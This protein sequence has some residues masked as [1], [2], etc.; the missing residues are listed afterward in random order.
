MSRTWPLVVLLSLASACDEPH[1]WFN[2]TPRL[3]GFVDTSDSSGGC[4]GFPDFDQ[5]GYGEEGS[6]QGNVDCAF[7]AADAGD[8]NDADATVFPDAQER[9]DGIDSNCNG[10][11]DDVDEAAIDQ[12]TTYYDGDGDGYGDR[13]GGESVKCPTD[14]WV[15][16]DG[17]CN[18]GDF[19]VRPGAAEVCDGLDNDCDG[20][21]DALDPDMPSD[22][23]NSVY[24]ADLDGDS[25]GNPDVVRC[26]SGPGTVTNGNDCNDSDAS[27]H[28]NAAEACDDVDRDCSGATDDITQSVV[29]Y[30][31][32]DGDGWGS[33]TAGG[34][35]N[36]CTGGS[37]V[38]RSGD[39]DDE[40]IARY[41]GAI[42]IPYDGVMNDCNYANSADCDADRDGFF[43][44]QCSTVTPFDCN[45]DDALVHPGALQLSF[46]GVDSDCDGDTA[47]G[48][49]H[50]P[51]FTLSSVGSEVAA[52]DL[53]GDGLVELIS[54][55]GAA[56]SGANERLLVWPNELSATASSSQFGSVS[57]AGRRTFTDAMDLDRDGADD[58]LL[59][60]R[61]NEG[62]V[63]QIGGGT[64]VSVY[65]SQAGGPDHFWAVGDV[66][67]DGWGDVFVTL[68]S[69]GNPVLRHFAVEDDQ[70]VEDLNLS[71]PTNE[72][73]LGFS[74]A[75]IPGVNISMVGD[76]DGDGVEE[77][78]IG[79]PE[80]PG[81]GGDAFGARHILQGPD[82]SWD[83]G[84]GYGGGG[85]NVRLGIVAALGQGDFNGDGYNEDLSGGV[86]PTVGD[87]HDTELITFHGHGNLF[88]PDGT[89]IYDSFSLPTLGT[90]LV[91]STRWAGDVD[92]DGTDD[93][94]V[95]YAADNGFDGG[96]SFYPDA[97]AHLVFGRSTVFNG[98]LTDT[99]YAAVT[100]TPET[101]DG[102][103][104]GMALLDLDGHEP[105]DLVL[106]Q[107]DGG[108]ALFFTG[109][110]P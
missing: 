13:L 87:L 99:N 8:C 10:L 33:N 75:Y 1:G 27:I 94:W 96:Q 80:L 102:L 76:M 41:P 35:V 16:N 51:M 45:D 6:A 64:E 43:S 63:T 58:V 100:P 72:F 84:S 31:D 67:N 110:A 44:S 81:D 55:A 26:G 71:S 56:S 92:G 65:T 2:G 60:T 78:S 4:F 42:D 66:D 90:N 19:S 57:V 17:D 86:Y 83:S 95:S 38:G 97:G 37:L 91:V 85:Q 74:G 69:G 93:F 62:L 23:P 39:C 24:F 73:L 9:C 47:A 22:D 18:D 28:P 109:R 54:L 89:F 12:V 32:S 61:G 34:T 79:M 98:Y 101:H 50:K 11:S 40:D 107:D 7:V 20:L 5:D 3:A 21:A 103:A 77:V 36:S 49:D 68:L 105:L 29:G 30:I 70:S 82:Y 88:R 59:F 46:G 108:P 104:S 15:A 25:F 52:A 48:G 14:Q 106:A 53:N